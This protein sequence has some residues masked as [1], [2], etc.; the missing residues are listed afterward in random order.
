MPAIEVSKYGQ[1]SVRMARAAKLLR[2][3]DLAV[4][5][6]IEQVGYQN[7]SFFR[8]KFKETYGRTPA[9]YRKKH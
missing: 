1:E 9:Q 4:A 8:R 3:S 2:E 7:D 5:E 6:I